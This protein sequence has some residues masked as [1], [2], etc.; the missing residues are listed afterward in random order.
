[1][2]YFN[3]YFC[4]LLLNILEKIWIMTLVKWRCLEVSVTNDKLIFK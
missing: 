2:S 1:M 3:L 4:F